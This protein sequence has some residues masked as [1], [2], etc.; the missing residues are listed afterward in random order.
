MSLNITKSVQSFLKN[1]VNNNANTSN[2]MGIKTNVDDYIYIIL[3]LAS[4]VMSALNRL[5]VLR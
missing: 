3:L 1:I 2:L 5:K 4:D